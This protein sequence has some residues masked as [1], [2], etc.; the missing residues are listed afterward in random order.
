MRI[1]IK[2]Y[3]FYVVS[4]YSLS[5]NKILLIVFTGIFFVLGYPRS[6]HCRKTLVVIIHRWPGYVVTILRLY[7]YPGNS[8]YHP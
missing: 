3:S 7:T 6:I 8:Y 4:S 2:Y 5:C 1:F